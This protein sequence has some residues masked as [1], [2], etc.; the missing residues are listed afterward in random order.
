MR[1]I[2]VLHQS[3]LRQSCSM[4]NLF[5]FVMHYNQ[6]GLLTLVLAN[7]SCIHHFPR[8]C[9]P[10]SWFLCKSFPNSIN[11]IIRKYM[12][13]NQMLHKPFIPYVYL[14]ENVSIYI[15]WYGREPQSQGGD[16]RRSQ[17][18]SAPTLSVCVDTCS[19]LSPEG[20]LLFHS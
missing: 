19:V 2:T 13:S 16:Q 7:G 6:V 5:L 10:H 11:K 14:V 20:T 12:Y 4:I 18:P 17:P 3:A 9:L 1:L 15:S 8:Q